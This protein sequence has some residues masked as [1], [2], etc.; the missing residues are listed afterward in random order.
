MPVRPDLRRN[1]CQISD[2]KNAKSQ[3]IR[4]RS[5]KIGLRSCVLSKIR[6]R[7]CETAIIHN[8]RNPD[9]GLHC[10]ASSRSAL[11]NQGLEVRHT[12]AATSALFTYSS[13]AGMTKP[14][15]RTPSPPYPASTSAKE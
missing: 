8:S 12:H 13:S 10:H 1:E 3:T 11:R 2:E 15:G 4:L 14:A 9:G 7:S 6:L 5:C